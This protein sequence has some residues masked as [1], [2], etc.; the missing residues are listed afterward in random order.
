MGY[1]IKA[2]PTEIVTAKVTL[3]SANLLAGNYIYDIPEYPQVNDYFWNVI[4][5]CGQIVNGSTP[6]TGNTQIHIQAAN[7]PFFQYR[8]TSNLMQEP[9]SFFGR[10]T[11][12]I[13]GSQFKPNDN[14]QIHTGSALF[15]GD[16]DL[17]IYIGANLIPY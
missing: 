3:T 15:A 10:A 8:F 1:L 14:L 12:N 17:N 2:I 6:Y 9:I 13:T 16:T 11:I 7:A 5:M 4:Y